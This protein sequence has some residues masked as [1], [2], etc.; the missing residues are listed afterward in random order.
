VYK[1]DRSQNYDPGRTSYTIQNYLSH[2]FLKM[3][4]KVMSRLKFE[5]EYNLNKVEQKL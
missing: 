4:A 5:I 2:R 1:E 3:I